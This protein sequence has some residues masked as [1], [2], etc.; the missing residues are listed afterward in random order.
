MQDKNKNSLQLMN[1]EIAL[2]KGV[3]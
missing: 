3:Q 1:W 2:K